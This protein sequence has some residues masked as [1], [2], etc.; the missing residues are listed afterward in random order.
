MKEKAISLGTRSEPLKQM[1]Q[2]KC[3]ERAVN[4][5]STRSKKN[6]C[7]WSSKKLKIELKM[8]FIRENFLFLI[9]LQE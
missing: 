5:R 6:K 8:L 1:I 7:E 4:D 3:E 9:E 2:A